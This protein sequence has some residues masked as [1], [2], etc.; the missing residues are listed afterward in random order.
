MNHGRAGVKARSPKL[1][2]HNQRDVMGAT[3]DDFSKCPRTP[4]LFGSRGAADL[5]HFGGEASEAFV[6]DPSLIG[7]EKLAGTNVGIHFIAS[8][9][10]VRQCRG[11]EITEGMPPHCS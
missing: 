5:T 11:H 8:G 10:I 9:R 7:E 2:G 6:A 4:H 3:R 1:I